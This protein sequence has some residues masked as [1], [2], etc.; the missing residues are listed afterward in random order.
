MLRSLNKE[1]NHLKQTLKNNKKNNSN[2]K[3]AIKLYINNSYNSSQPS[4]FLTE[5]KVECNWRESSELT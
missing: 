4:L 5:Q 3:T 1:A 2:K